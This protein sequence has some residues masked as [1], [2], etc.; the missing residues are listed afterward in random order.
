MNIDID[1]LNRK[2][3][4]PEPSEAF[5]QKMQDD[6]IAKIAAEKSIDKNEKKEA[7][8]FSLNFK[9]MAAAAV[10][11]IAGITAFFGFRNDNNSPK[12]ESSFA[13]ETAKQNQMTESVYK[14]DQP[15]QS[16]LADNSE[17]KKPTEKIH[18]NIRENHEHSVAYNQN[19]KI[20]NNGA[21]AKTDINIQ[22]YS[23]GRNAN[24]A[25]DV[26]KVLVAFTSE[27]IRD[28]D[29]NSEQDIYLDLY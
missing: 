14:I 17:T 3:P 21:S 12:T 24:S 29:R 11:L 10:I 18:E 19:S 13:L 9:W 26:D 22:D 6:V 5:F 25:I 4:Y 8:I 28:I 1:K 15:K 27:Q 7:K 2:M 20:K 16:A 23:V